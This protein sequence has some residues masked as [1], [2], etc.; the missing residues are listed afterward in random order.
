MFGFGDKDPCAA[1][2]RAER[3][4]AGAGSAPRLPGLAPERGTPPLLALQATSVRH[5]C[6]LAVTRGQTRACATSRE[7]ASRNTHWKSLEP[8]PG[9]QAGPALF[10]CPLAPLKGSSPGPGDR[11]KVTVAGTEAVLMAASTRDSRGP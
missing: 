7:W 8:N 11:R 9:P 2:T 1:A 5:C 6:H 10:T 4:R 3:G